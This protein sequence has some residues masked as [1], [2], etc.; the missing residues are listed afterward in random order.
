MSITRDRRERERAERHRLILAVARELAE[1]EGWEAVTTRR[2][3]ERVEY[4]QPVLYSHF[5]GKDAMV[6][7]VA[8]QGFAELAE[9]LSHARTAARGR[10][11]RRG[12]RAV[13]QAYLRFAV[14]HPALYRAMFVMPTRLKFASE[15]TPTALRTAFD[16]IVAAFPEE[17]AER[18]ARAE[19]LWA[20]LHGISALSATGRVPAHGE[21]TRLDLLI[22]GIAPS[23]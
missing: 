21:S 16:A 2:L 14:E 7:A 3:A 22:E 12:L 15:E 5:K 11:S 9:L 19:L 10:G 6:A 8:E 18:E 20:A 13:C 4:S 17:T 23:G 1:A